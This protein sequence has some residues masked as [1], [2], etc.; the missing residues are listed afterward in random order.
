MS[1]SSTL[2]SF[3]DTSNDHEVHYTLRGLKDD[4]VDAWTLFCEA[5]F[6]YKRPHPPPASYFA[7]HF[8]N[9]PHRDASLVRVAIQDEAI[10]ASC[11]VFRRNITSPIT[12]QICKAGGI[13]EVCTHAD[14]RRRGLSS[15]LLQQAV[16]AMKHN[17]MAVSFLHSAPTFFPVY[18]KAGYVSVRSRWSVVTIS[19]PTN[20]QPKNYEIRTAL[21]PHD[22]LTLRTLHH[23]YSEMRFSGCIVRSEAYWNEYI[24]KE[25]ENSL[26]VLSR[27]GGKLEC[28]MSIR[29]KNGRCQLREFGCDKG[30][31]LSE[32][33]Y[34]LFLHCLRYSQPSVSGTVELCLPTAILEE[35]TRDVGDTIPWIRDYV[36]EDDL[37]W[38]YKNLKV[39]GSSTMQFDSS[40]EHLI[41]PSDSF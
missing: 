20:L 6:A 36:R 23:Q 30:T 24:A 25:L 14:H 22:T 18:E 15:Q 7:R 31:A 38:M 12:S 2:Y 39:E 10:V 26:F 13:G 33:F 37:G 27:N 29:W 8:Y 19:I 41:W 11:R 4:E 35:L 16:S 21:F 17:V 28:W 1:D 40:K 5:V 34:P 9:D 3:S 32:V